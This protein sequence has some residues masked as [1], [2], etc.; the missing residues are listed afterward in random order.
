MRKFKIANVF[1]REILDSRGNPTI[2]T[3]VTLKNGVIGTAAVPSGASTGIYEAVELR[4][5]DKKRYLGKGVLKAVENVNTTIKNV[6]L[7]M[8]ASEQSEMDATLVNLD[9]TKNKSVLGANAILSVSL[10][11]AKAVANAKKMPLYEYIKIGHANTLPVPL[12]N[13]LNGGAHAGNNI[14]IQEFMIV[15]VGAK[16]FSEAIRW[17]AE[18]FHNLNKVLKG[19]SL[20]CGIGDEGGY[21]PNLNSNEEALEVILESIKQAGYNTTNQIKIAIDAAASEWANGENSYLMPKCKKAYTRDELIEFWSALVK[22]YPIISLEDPMGEED[23]EGWNKLTKKLGNTVQ[24]V[25][26]DLYV[27][28]TERLALGIEQHSSNSILIKLNQ[29]GTLTE[30]IEA[31]KMAQKAGFTTV[32]S[33]RSGETEDTTIADLAVATGSTQIKTGSTSRS[34][35]IAKYNRLMKIELDLGLNAKYLG[36]DSFNMKDTKK[37]NADTQN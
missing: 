18:V 15:P 9:G 20:A 13:I 31:I 5:N 25:G 8:D 3:T 19:K 27:T 1:A 11:C 24:I 10:A 17:C 22:K 12:C 21:A 7:G 16:N 34:E 29:I 32:I 26:D 2:E 6:I 28:N 37:I 14:D 36:L 4:D 33:H 23:F 30:T 35:R